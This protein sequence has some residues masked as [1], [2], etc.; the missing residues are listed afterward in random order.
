MLARKTIL[1]QLAQRSAVRFYSSAPTSAIRDLLKDE[2]KKAMKAKNMNDINIVKSIMADITYH[3]KSFSPPKPA[4]DESVYAVI[5]K[6][7]NRRKESAA[8]FQSGNRTDL[9]D[10]ETLEA[11]FIQKFLPAALSNDEI[12]VILERLLKELAVPQGDIKSVGKLL[13]AFWSEIARSKA[14][15]TLVA[16]IAKELLGTK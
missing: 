14:D 1:N 10:K 15:G 7:I 12:K 2:F 3:E 5:Q 11:E 6:A 4:D 16:K 9:A 13:K 8:Q